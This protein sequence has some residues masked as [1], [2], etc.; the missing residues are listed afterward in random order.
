MNILLARQL[1][2]YEFEPCLTQKYS[3][4]H[5]IALLTLKFVEAYA[6][7]FSRAKSLRQIF[8]VSRSARWKLA[9]AVPVGTSARNHALFV[10]R[11]DVSLEVFGFST[12]VVVRIVNYSEKSCSN[13]W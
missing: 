13:R 1:D 4:N 10:K 8:A 7:H 5:V 9:P 3:H 11:A 2:S 6:I 12:G